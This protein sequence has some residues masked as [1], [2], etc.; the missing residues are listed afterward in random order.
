MLLMSQKNSQSLVPIT[1][2][3]CR[4]FSIMTMIGSVFDDKTEKVSDDDYRQGHSPNEE[5]DLYEFYKCPKCKK[6]NVR[7]YYFSQWH[8]EDPDEEMLESLTESYFTVI[9]PINKSTVPIG[10]PENISHQYSIAEKTK[11]IDIGLYAISVR[12]LLELV[13]K[14]NGA[15]TGNLVDKIKELVSKNILPEKLSKVADGIRAFGNI[16]AHGEL[17]ELTE[18]ELPIIN[19]LTRAILEYLYTA[20]YLATV[21]EKKLEALKIR[22]KLENP[23]SVS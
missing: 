11:E 10:L 22:K 17:D 15:K 20:P 12:K 14:E 6:V 2:G 7:S 18:K 21:A 16:G 8:H 9:Y 5:G 3:H 13:C 23:H 1:C 4:N 19:A